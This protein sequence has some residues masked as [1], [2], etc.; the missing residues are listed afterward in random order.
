MRP[1]VVK[2]EAEWRAELT[3][4]QFHVTRQA[5]TERP[6][7]GPWLHEKRAGTYLCVA[8][9]QPLSGPR[10]SIKSGSGWPSFFEPI[11]GEAVEEITDQSHGMVRGP[12]CAAR[13]A[14]PI[15]ATSSPTGRGRPACATA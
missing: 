9:G 8:C 7:T 10:P 6:G 3:P 13:P 12:R 1:K 4:A 14:N 11:A 15:S 2:S 5:G